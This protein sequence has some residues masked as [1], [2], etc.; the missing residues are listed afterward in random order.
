MKEVTTSHT[1]NAE[2]L[3]V[4]LKG[5]NV[6]VLL[7]APETLEH[8]EDGP[9]NWLVYGANPERAREIATSLIE[10]ADIIEGKR[11]PQPGEYETGPRGSDAF[12]EHRHE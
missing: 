7:E 10:G 11:I 2:Q 8:P 4:G 6:V 12:R 1:Y 9:L 3:V 5:G